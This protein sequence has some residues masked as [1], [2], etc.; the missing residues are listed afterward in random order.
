MKI[1]KER[2][3]GIIKEEVSNAVNEQYEGSPEQELDRWFSGRGI[4]THD[5]EA[6][7]SKLK[8]AGW[9]AP[10]DKK[11][12]EDLDELATG[13]PMPKEDDGSPL[14]R[15]N[16]KTP[17]LE[18][19]QRAVQEAGQYAE[20]VALYDFLKSK[21]L[22]DEKVQEVF[23]KIKVTPRVWEEREKVAEELEKVAEELGI[24]KE[25][26]VKVRGYEVG[27]P[28]PSPIRPSDYNRS[29]NELIVNAVETR[30]KKLE[31][32]YGSLIKG[33]EEMNKRITKTR[34]DW[35]QAFDAQKKKRP[36]DPQAALR[37]GS[38][39]KLGT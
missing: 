28:E 25:D 1:T 18:D 26:S 39:G 34:D 30:L 32:E 8:A 14:R 3:M 11:N 37:Y 24:T 35:K 13:N 36:H 9:T 16:V 2:L 5:K 19:A 27:R 21:G 22:T 31:T 15:E 29:V 23:D 17:N 6:L 38:T 10:G 20:E 4:K 33:L 7:F 12:E